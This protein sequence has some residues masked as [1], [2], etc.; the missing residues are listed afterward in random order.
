MRSQ[1]AIGIDINENTICAVELK[2]SG[3]GVRLNRC[4]STPMPAE[5]VRKGSVVDPQA[6]AKAVKEVLRKGRI[7]TRGRS[8]AVSLAGPSY[9]ARNI[10]LP[11]G[12]PVAVREHIQQEVKRYAV[13]TREQTVSDFTIDPGRGTEEDRTAFL[14]ATTEQSASRLVETMK[15]ARIEPA[16]VDISV[17]ATARALCTG[18]LRLT[19]PS[20][21][22]LAFV[23]P[24]AVHLMVFMGKSICFSHTTLETVNLSDETGEDAG[25]LTLMIRSVLDYYDSEIGNLSDIDR[26]VVCGECEP[27]EN[28]RDRLS[29]ALG[30]FPVTY[31]HPGTI[32]ADTEIQAEGDAPRP[33]AGAVG[34]AMR[35]IDEDAFAVSLNMLPPHVLRAREF[36]RR[37]ALAGVLAA[38]LLLLAFLAKGGISWRQKSIDAEIARVKKEVDA[39]K[40][41]PAALRLQTEIEEMEGTLTAEREFVDREGPPAPWPSMLERIREIIPKDLRLTQMEQNGSGGIVMAGEALSVESVYGFVAPLDNG[42]FTRSARLANMNEIGYGKQALVQFV[43]DCRL[44]H[45]DDW[46]QK[47][48]QGDG[49][50][51]ASKGKKTRKSVNRKGK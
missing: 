26:L 38:S 25:K 29:K 51:K 47:D 6:A 49:R 16:V 19:P 21:A 4:A 22:V 33:T 46:A 37:L 10:Q 48:R 2:A 7:S 34:L 13:F 44:R 36:K 31:C 45:W 40:L 5:V 27:P 18:P 12:G 30:D 20:A 8:V 42:E 43:L 35:I 32:V 9:V 14:A 41:S 24:G 28:A 23:E 15:R 11:P 3:S 1:T 50:E 39:V 17:L